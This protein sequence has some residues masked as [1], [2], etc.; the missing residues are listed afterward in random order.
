MSKEIDSKDLTINDMRRYLAYMTYLILKEDFPH[1]IN[2]DYFKE[3][4]SV[5]GYK[6][7]ENL[8]SGEKKKMRYFL[9]V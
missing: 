5:K 2:F 4:I 9:E 3:E 8:D 7:P 1:N 6:K